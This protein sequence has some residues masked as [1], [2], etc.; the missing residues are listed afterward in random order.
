MTGQPP[1]G[2][3]RIYTGQY[4]DPFMEYDRGAQGSYGEPQYRENPGDFTLPGGPVSYDTTSYEFPQV[5]S[6]PPPGFEPQGSGPQP[7]FQPNPGYQPGTGPQP[8]FQP[9]GGP[10]P[11]NGPQPGHGPHHTGPHKFNRPR[12]RTSTGSMTML[13]SALSDFGFA[14]FATPTIVPVLY[15]L[16][17]AV[18]VLVALGVAVTAFEVGLVFGVVALF[19]LAPAVFVL[20]VGFSRLFMEVC[21]IAFRMGGETNQSAP[22]AANQDMD[23]Y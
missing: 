2:T 6:D 5:A 9:A 10:Q 7:G 19:V 21:L 23:R 11:G 20:G 12:T 18:W 4:G 13:K 8:G 14:S 17:V 16:S 1:E 3:E 15:K 22:E